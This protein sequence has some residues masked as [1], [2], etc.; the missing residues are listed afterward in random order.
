LLLTYVG[1]DKP[2][3]ES[4]NHL[5]MAEAEHFTGGRSH[6]F[7]DLKEAI[8]RSSI[9]FGREPT[10]YTTVM[11][12][13]TEYKGNPYNFKQIREEITSMKAN[14]R[15]HN[16]SLGDDPVDYTSDYTRGYGSI[17]A[18]HY[19]SA[20]QHRE[21]MQKIKADLRAT[22]WVFGQEKVNYMSDTHEA[23][24]MAEGKARADE[25]QRNIARAKQMKLE[26]QKTSY[27][28]GNDDDYQ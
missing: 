8:K 7:S 22:H 3:Y 10:N 20:G 14:L 15:K 17:G 6:I 18:D 12:E 26:L 13:A 25:V 19:R 2:E 27:V 24:K 21:A 4:I 11:R 5:A 9:T 28:I 23:L 16:F 1:D